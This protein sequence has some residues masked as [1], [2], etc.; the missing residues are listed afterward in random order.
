MTVQVLPQGLRT[1]FS[2]D[3]SRVLKQGPLTDDLTRTSPEFEAS[4]K[5]YLTAGVRT[6]LADRIIAGLFVPDTGKPTV[7][8]SKRQSTVAKILLEMT[9]DKDPDIKRLGYEYIAQCI[10]HPGARNDQGALKELFT[11]LY[12]HTH[13]HLLEVASGEFND[14]WPGNLS[15]FELVLLSA[16]SEHDLA[17]IS[18]QLA[19]PVNPEDLKQERPRRKNPDRPR[20]ELTPEQKELRRKKRE[21]RRRL[22]Q[23]DSSKSS[24]IRRVLQDAMRERNLPQAAIKGKWSLADFAQF[25][26]EQS[27]IIANS[28]RNDRS[29]SGLVRGS[30]RPIGA[31]PLIDSS[32]RKQ[33]GYTKEYF[34]LL[35]TTRPGKKARD[36]ITN[37]SRSTSTPD[38]DRATVKMLLL[39]MGQGNKQMEKQAYTHFLTILKGDDS[40]KRK[41]I[42]ELYNLLCAKYLQTPD[43]GKDP[44]SSLRSMS[45]FELCVLSSAMPNGV[46]F[47]MTSGMDCNISKYLQQEMQDRHLFDA[48]VQQK[49]ALDRKLEIPDMIG[50]LTEK[51]HKLDTEIAKSPLY[52]REDAPEENPSGLVRNYKLSDK[53][54]PLPSKDQR[55]KYEDLFLENG[56]SIEQE[57]QLGTERLERMAKFG[58]RNSSYS[59]DKAVIEVLVSA[60]KDKDP[61]RKE[62]GYRY[63]GQILEMNNAASRAVTLLLENT[64]AEIEARRRKACKVTADGFLDWRQKDGSEKDVLAR[65]HSFNKFML[66]GYNRGRD[67]VECTSLD[68]VLSK[69]QLWEKNDWTVEHIAGYCKGMSN[70]LARKLVSGN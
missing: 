51:I 17:S 70:R 36:L 49:K 46:I 8:R 61:A 52:P 60:I 29:L 12:A 44:Q 13:A 43:L 63:L 11:H 37:F 18:A 35:W 33:E 69:S 47:D 62:K 15:N 50:L 54:T 66:N 64:F 16:T 38:R 26:Q 40:G 67:G 20:K 39:L 32:E 10:N 45:D 41:L 56:K 28:K 23:I 65:L 3:L 4:I 5:P 48:E 2:G 58:T 19:K 34:P 42:S 1:S 25:A 59:E 24:N 57:I 21:E 7:S 9:V 55:K 68:E 22:R 31:P 27:R 30:D 6:P 53:L 14:L